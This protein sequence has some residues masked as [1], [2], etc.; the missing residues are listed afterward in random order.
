ML[1]NSYQKQSNLVIG[2]NVLINEG[3]EKQTDRT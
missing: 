2:G 3:N 1:F